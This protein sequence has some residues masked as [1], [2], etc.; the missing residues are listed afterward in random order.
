M[1]CMSLCASFVIADWDGKLWFSSG[2]MLPSG[3]V[4][5]PD[6]GESMFMDLM[7]ISRAVASFL[8]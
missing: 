8:E 1:V 2:M 7:E 4:L 3:A 5:S 6:T